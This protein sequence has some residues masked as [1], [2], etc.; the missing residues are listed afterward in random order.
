[1][2]FRLV[3]DYS[4]K[5]DQGTAIEALVRGVRDREQHQVLLGVTGSGKTYTMAKV[6]EE[7]N[8]PALVMAHNK[9]LAAQLYHEFKSFF[10]HNAVEYFVSYYDY[11]QPEAYVPAADLYIEKEATINDELDKLRL[12]ATRSLFERRDVLIVAS[13]SCI[14]GL[15]SPE[16][17]Y[18]MLLFLEKGQKIKREDITRKLVEILYERTEGDFRRGTF[19]VRGDVIEVYPTYDDFA[20]RIELW[21]DEVESLAQIDPLFGTVKQKYVRLPIYPKTHYVMKPETRSRAVETIKEELAWWEKEL[22]KQGRMVE[23]QRVHQRTMYDLEMIKAM[24]YCH[25]IENY[26]RHFTGR[27][28]GEPP[29]TLLDYFARDYLMFIDES[30][31]TVPQLHGMYHGDRS[32][33]STLVEYGF[34]LPSALDNRPLT[35]EEFE[36]RTNQLIY[37]SATP[38]PYELTKS[39]GVVVEQVIRPTGLVDPP[40]EVRP[41]KGQID[42]LL[43]E[44]RQ[45]VERG[46][47]ALVTTLTK[48]MAEDLA[49]YYSEVGVK[50]RYMHSE[51]EVLERVKILRDLRRGEFDVLIGINLL[52][53]GLD[54]PEVSL[55]AVLDAD[56]EGFLRSTGS[57]IQ[58]V[59]RCARNLNGRAVLYADRMTESMQ[60]AIDETNRRRAIQEAYNAANGITPQSI[61]RRLDMSLAHIVEADYTDLASADAD[62]LPDFKSQEELDAFITKLETEM[63]ENA[64]RF[65][66]EKAAKLRDRI[67]E[68]RTKE[69]LF[70]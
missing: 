55:V 5:G 2:D 70:A 60:K 63:R 41:V 30:H 9:T 65:E 6:I 39:A 48:R 24:G 54:L 56:K 61:V 12:S 44:I 57:L 4:P 36:H 66:F 23:A 49:E 1:M 19:R 20:Y 51:I 37:V 27:M 7:I 13:V 8:R 14:Y 53:E 52:R 58:T 45:R 26:S 25:G 17:Y 50:C 64:K 62:G 67:K 29:P 31:Q 33:K 59:G 32:R 40:V 42:D 22:E 11:Y 34:R 47:R 69:F 43:H 15:G 46:E 10:P 3:S 28:P 35:F 38:G 21:G 68:M 18:G 16:A